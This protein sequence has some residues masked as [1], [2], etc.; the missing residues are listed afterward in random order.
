MRTP[1]EQVGRVER[2]EGLWRG[3]LKPASPAGR[4]R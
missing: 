1:D 3:I 2:P 4:V